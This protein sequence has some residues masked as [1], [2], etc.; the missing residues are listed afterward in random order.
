MPEPE[1]ASEFRLVPVCAVVLPL[2]SSENPMEATRSEEHVVALAATLNVEFTVDLSAGLAM[3]MS[4]ALVF[5]GCESPELDP[6]L[7]VVLPEPEAEDEPP[8]VPLVLPEL[9]ED[10]PDPVELPPLLL[11]PEELLPEPAV[12]PDPDDEV[13]ESPKLLPVGDPD[14][15]EVFPEP[16]PEPAAVLPVSADEL[17]GALGALADEA[18]APMG[19]TAALPHPAVNVAARKS[20]DKGSGACKRRNGVLLMA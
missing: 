7:L 20:A 1:V 6:E 8:K 9:L 3:M 14:P 18:L 11:L 19:I 5:A 17:P 10:P 13:P 12:L 2:L 4:F 16:V 15:D